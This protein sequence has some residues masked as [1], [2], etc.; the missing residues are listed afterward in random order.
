[1]RSATAAT[2]VVARGRHIRLGEL[3]RR[4]RHDFRSEQIA[5]C[6]GALGRRCALGGRLL[7]GDLSGLV[8]AAM[9]CRWM[10]DLSFQTFTERIH[11]FLALEHVIIGLGKAPCFALAIATIAF[12]LYGVPSSSG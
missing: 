3:E 8:G 12:A 4:R 7:I 1:M 11:S 6:R 5:P 9:V 2:G 10:L